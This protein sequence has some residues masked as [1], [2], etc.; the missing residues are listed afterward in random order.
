MAEPKILFKSETEEK[1]FPLIRNR[2]R[3][4]LEDMAGD[5]EA[6]GHDFIVTDL[7]EEVGERDRLARVSRSHQDGRAAD[8]RVKHLPKEFI[9]R[10]IRKFSEKYESWA[11]LSANGGLPCLIVY[12]DNGNG[13]HFHIQI[14]PYKEG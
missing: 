9:Q 14:K 2:L 7:L 12:H 5:F 1:E 13:I 10:I 8:V 11:A 6:E 4:I 3:I